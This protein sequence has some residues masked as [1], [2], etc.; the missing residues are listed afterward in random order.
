M[1]FAGDKLLL[2]PSSKITALLFFYSGFCF[3]KKLY[4]S[5]FTQILGQYINHLESSFFPLLQGHRRINIC[6]YE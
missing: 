5:C 3:G 2:R 4:T 1:K 6:L